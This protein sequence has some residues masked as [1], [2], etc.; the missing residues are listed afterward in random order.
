MPEYYERRRQNTYLVD[1]MQPA[2]DPFILEFIVNFRW[3]LNYVTQRLDLVVEQHYPQIIT[4]AT[5][6]EVTLSQS[7]ATIASLGAIPFGALE[8]ARSGYYYLLLSESIVG[9]CPPTMHPFLIKAL[10]SPCHPVMGCRAV[11]SEEPAMQSTP[12]PQLS[13]SL[14]TSFPSHSTIDS[15][16]TRTHSPTARLNHGANKNEVQAMTLLLR[17]LT[18]ESVVVSEELA[19]TLQ[20]P[21]LAAD[22]AMRSA[23]SHGSG[24][25]STKKL[26]VFRVAAERLAQLSPFYLG[27]HVLV[28]RSLLMQYT[29][30]LLPI[31]SIAEHAGRLRTDRHADIRTVEDALLL[32]MRSVVFLVKERESS[33]GA[34]AGVPSLHWSAWRGWL[35]LQRDFYKAI[36]DG[37]G[38]C[39][40]LYFYQ[41]AIISLG[42]VYFPDPCTITEKNLSVEKCRKNWDMVLSA[43]ARVGVWVGLTADEM[44]YC[45]D[46]LQL[47]LLRIAVELFAALATHAE[48]EVRASLEI[49]REEEIQ[50]SISHSGVTKCTHPTTEDE[51]QVR[52]ASNEA[53]HNLPDCAEEAPRA[54]GTVIRAKRREQSFAPHREG[55]ET[56][57]DPLRPVY[58]SSRT[59]SRT[60]LGS[61]REG[62][63]SVMIASAVDTSIML[64]DDQA[65][66]INLGTRTSGGNVGMVDSPRLPHVAGGDSESGRLLSRA[67]SS[68]S[69]SSEVFIPQKMHAAQDAGVLPSVVTVRGKF[70]AERPAN[71]PEPMT[72]VSEST[73]TECQEAADSEAAVGDSPDA[74]RETFPE[75]HG[76]PAAESSA[77]DDGESASHGERVV[78]QLLKS[79]REHSSVL[80]HQ[81]RSPNRVSSAVESTESALSIAQQAHR[82]SPLSHDATTSTSGRAV[83]HQQL[84]VARSTYLSLTPVDSLDHSEREMPLQPV[85]ATAPLQ[86]D[87]E[88]TPERVFSSGV[89][90]NQLGET[91]LSRSVSTVENSTAASR[92]GDHCDED[93]WFSS[94]SHHGD[95]MLQ[96]IHDDEDL[97]EL[98]RHLLSSDRGQHAESDNSV[99]ALR[100]TIAKQQEIIQ[101]MASRL[102]S[103]WCRS[104]RSISPRSLA[105]GSKSLSN[106]ELRKG[107]S[108]QMAKRFDGSS[109]VGGCATTTP[110]QSTVQK[111]ASPSLPHATEDAGGLSTPVP[112]QEGSVLYAASNGKTHSKRSWQRHSPR[113]VYTTEEIDRMCSS[114]ISQVRDSW[115][116]GTSEVPRSMTL[117]KD[118]GT[119]L[120][121]VPHNMTSSAENWTTNSP[122]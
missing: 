34:V 82:E 65:P 69:R 5:D 114:F 101:K 85:E 43:M 12:R 48:E 104:P 68:S 8:M 53:A 107:V 105:V 56:K 108:F 46:T 115:V 62:G 32:W 19:D 23:R 31:R 4:D 6:M 96:C 63:R 24:R 103:S 99:H 77:P 88:S 86:E 106:V 20:L 95:H 45:A 102:I 66:F 60:P 42:A 81:R 30:T 94:V 54:A 2:T 18:L 122:L 64:H 26:R 57:Q 35:Q 121:A 97:R 36:Y 40:I 61:A 92:I 70:F 98:M 83:Q 49:Q 91:P 93:S 21:E 72:P 28:T 17:W 25:S 109:R 52:R 44:V 89:N 80:P 73:T 79:Q 14:S 16:T 55:V 51:E 47:H 78:L 59:S 9:S 111:E 37:V 27:A 1:G 3:L 113:R 75:W 118:S 112:S 117:S 22:T 38:F 33:H 39:I 13:D 58:R 7:F 71:S 100:Q 119:A 15:Q 87:S 10:A 11:P 50:S 76:T 90:R 74:K 67:A 84:A 41:P 116:A 120:C 29:C 110:K